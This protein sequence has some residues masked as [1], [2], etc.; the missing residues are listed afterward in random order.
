MHLAYLACQATLPGSPNR[1][2]DAF[3]H[4][5]MMDCLRPAFKAH[6][7]TVTDVSWDDETVDWSRFDAVLIGTTWDYQDN[8]PAFLSVLEHIET[9]T[10]VFNSRALIKWN[11]D[12]CYLRDLGDKGV[13]LIPTIWM[14][15]VT[16]EA[17]A[18]AFDTLGAD[19]LIAKRQVG[20]GAEGQHKLKRGEVVPE[21]PHAM[22]VQPFMPS[23]LEEGE[24]SFVFIGGEFSHAL[25]KTAADG[26]YRIQSCYG[27]IETPI[28]PSGEDIAAA[29]AVLAACD[30]TPLYA[31]IDMVRA[32][33]GGLVLME[34]ELVEP[35]LYPLQGPELGTRLYAALKAMVG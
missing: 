30:E 23:I 3:E 14:D 27:G 22:M 10:P 5:Q 13:R 6:G 16:P 1:R 25:L 12:K 7:G 19:T 24:L 32:D 34:M 26:D 33:D 8:L 35:F 4:D 28:E 20:A 31:R 29:K 18:E 21:M 11:T 2:V 15:K 17:I 9:H